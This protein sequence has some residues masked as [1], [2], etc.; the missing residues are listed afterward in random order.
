MDAG[1]DDLIFAMAAKEDFPGWGHMIRQGATTLWE[2]WQEPN[3]LLH[4]SFLFIGA[5]FIH[6]VLG[7]QLDARYPGFRRFVIRP[8]IVDPARLTW[9]RG[10]YDSIRGRIGVAWRWS[11]GRFE[12]SVSVPPNTTAEIRLPTSD[13]DSVAESGIPI[14]RSSAFRVLGI[15]E[16]RLVLEIG[17]GDYEFSTKLSETFISDSARSPML[18]HN[19][20]LDDNSVGN[21]D[22]TSDR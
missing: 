5:W 2:A 1:R 19:R 14:G 17:S 21:A 4:S 18:L 7:I 20:E 11:S 16:H 8:G 9:A 15:V 22:N 6:G 10:H 13:Q 12:L 3:S